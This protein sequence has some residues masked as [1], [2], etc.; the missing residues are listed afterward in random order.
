MDRTWW[1]EGGWKTTLW[2]GANADWPDVGRTEAE[3]GVFEMGCPQG[4]AK[5]TMLNNSLANGAFLWHHQVDFASRA[6]KLFPFSEDN[7]YA[8]VGLRFVACGRCSF[9][10]CPRAGSDRGRCVVCRA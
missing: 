10:C 4:I 5:R 6:P 3:A 8:P 9:F 2:L 7:D 1:R